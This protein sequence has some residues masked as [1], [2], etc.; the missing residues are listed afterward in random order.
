M[1]DAIRLAEA[2]DWDG[3]RRLVAKAPASAQACDGYGMLPIHWA[4]TEAS[5]PL[6]LLE[7]LLM[8]FPDG[9]S[10]VN[11]AGLLP[12]HIAIRAHASPTWLQALLSSHP[13]SIGVETPT[14]AT[15]LALAEH[16]GADEACLQV[17]RRAAQVSA[18]PEDARSTVSSS[19][20]SNV[21]RT[22]PK[23]KGLLRHL[24]F[25][26]T[27]TSLRSA[28]RPT[29]R[30]V[31]SVPIMGGCA[32][33]N[34]DVCE[35]LDDASVSSDDDDDV[36]FRGNNC[37]AVLPML[38]EEPPE[39]HLHTACSVC[40]AAFSMFKHRHH[41]RNCGKS[42]CRNHS[43]DKKVPTKGFQSPQRVC[44]ACY[45]A[46]TSRKHSFT[47][48]ESPT[49]T[50]KR[51]LLRVLT[52][53]TSPKPSPVTSP[54]VAEMSTDAEILTLKATVQQLTKQVDNLHIANMALQQQ[55]LEQ[56]ELKAETMLLIT[57]VMTRVSVLELQRVK[58]A[59]D[60]DFDI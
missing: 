15:P 11:S 33:N 2:S 31:T 39:W 9:A 59:N 41:C 53:L 34:A 20:G 37:A 26:Y 45:G 36:L 60:D 58:Q 28:T 44:I 54:I 29:V 24:S 17:L 13:E 43:A 14:G 46:L 47:M 57:Q 52:E 7:T 10:T 4:S 18:E 27:T 8:A 49:V 42:I 55:L 6:E 51:T 12:L 30:R 19:R 50:P 3:L 22:P 25:D 21:L 40:H 32:N 23:A 5:V 56:E 38:D 16:V 1:H 35:I 48:L